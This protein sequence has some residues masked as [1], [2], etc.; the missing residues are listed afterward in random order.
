MTLHCRPSD[1]TGRFLKMGHPQVTMGFST[2]VWSFM[3]WMIWGTPLLSDLQEELVFLFSPSASRPAPP[4]RTRPCHRS[5]MD[6]WDPSSDVVFPGHLRS[7]SSATMC[8]LP[9]DPVVV[10]GLSAKN[11]GHLPIEMIIF[12]HLHVFCLGWR[13][14]SRM[15]IETRLQNEGV[16]PVAPLSSPRSVVA[17]DSGSEWP[18]STAVSTSLG[19]GQVERMDALT[20]GRNE[21]NRGGDGPERSE[22]SEPNLAMI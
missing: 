13:W 6:Q 3:T 15:D 18:W 7:F 21:E 12:W 1:C 4:P 19:R 11:Y 20:R 17:C 14:W 8:S 16:F 2:V 22:R 5:Q 9:P 10:I